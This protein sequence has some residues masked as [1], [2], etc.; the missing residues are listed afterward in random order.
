MQRLESTFSTCCTT[1][2]ASICS[3]AEQQ[4]C[5]RLTHMGR[6]VAGLHTM[7]GTCRLHL[8][9][10]AQISFVILSCQL[11]SS[12]LYLMIIWICTWIGINCGHLACCQYILQQCACSRARLHYVKSDIVCV[13]TLPS[14]LWVGRHYNQR[15]CRCYFQACSTT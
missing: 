10:A 1:V 6:S 12:S 3:N 11:G 5:C 7:Q 14:S 9:F 4:V 2:L 8:S 15:Y 13:V